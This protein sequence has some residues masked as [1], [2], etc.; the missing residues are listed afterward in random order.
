MNLH[1]IAG[2]VVAAVN[3]WATATYKASTGYTTAPDGTRTPAFASPISVQVQMQPLTKDD[4]H[5]LDGLNLNGEKRAMYVS[6]D[7][8]GVSRPSGRGGDVITMPDGR[9][10]LIV[11]PLENFFDTSGWAKVAVVLQDMP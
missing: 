1:G 7:W 3:P 6:G 11:Q 10:W 2:G 5:Q 9:T 8:R 4:L